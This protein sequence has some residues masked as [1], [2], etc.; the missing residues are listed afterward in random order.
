MKPT[1]FRF[2]RYT[3]N[4]PRAELRCGEDAIELRPKSFDVL[5]YLIENAGRVV[6]KDE[7]F[8]AVWPDVTVT[9]DSLVQCVREIRHAVKDDDQRL[10]KTVQRRGYLFDAPVIRSNS[11]ETLDAAASE[12]GK[13]RLQASPALIAAGAAILLVVGLGA[14][15]FATSRSTPAVGTPSIAVLFSTSGDGSEKT[16]DYFS[17]GL[18][19][20]VIAALGRFSGLRVVVRTS[21]DKY[22]G[23]AWEPQ[24]LRRDLDVRYMLDGVVRRSGDRIRLTARL[25]DTSK[26]VLLWSDT[27][28]EEMKDVFA[29]QDRLTRNIVGRLAVRISRIEQQRANAIPTSN[30]QAY[31]FVLRGREKL[32][33]ITRADNL[34]ARRFFRLAA[35]LDDRY[36]SAFVGMGHTYHNDILFGWSPRLDEASRRAYEFANRG[37]ILDDK[38]PAGYLLLATIYVIQREYD[39]ALAEADRGIELNPHDADGYAVRGAVLVWM[40]RIDDAIAAFETAAQFDPNQSRPRSLA[41]LGI[42][43]LL[44][45]RHD[46]AVRAF[47]SSIGRN[48]EFTLAH[49]GLAA[50]YVE[51]GR[52]AEAERM[53]Q[54]IRQRDP[55]FSG[56][57]FGGQFAI[58]AHRTRISGNLQKIGL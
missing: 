41:H 51:L 40:G 2:D 33:H 4:L 52:R 27:Y 31:D 18:T 20:D 54:M 57:S 24:Q 42:A 23:T 13:A 35:D 26:G 25:T 15:W 6:S 56:A 46:D 43:Y 36:A 53:A 45:Q 39:L 28:D 11:T 19:D 3:L 48:P 12:N 49:I 47:E 16:Y 34:E 58:D 7:I 37:I 5:C 17:D 29:V 38:D 30:M 21:L 55:F 10:I 50:V 8:S 44:A 9:D 22:R 1:L 32:L 14:W